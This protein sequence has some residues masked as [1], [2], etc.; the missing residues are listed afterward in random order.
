MKEQG[1]VKWFRND[2]GYGFITPD[3]GGQDL[4]VHFS[5][6]AGKGY[7]SLEGVDRVEFTRLTTD[8]GQQATEVEALTP[9]A[10]DEEGSES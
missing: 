6:I 8:R 2:K 3:D 10:T 4:F 7:R 9:P 5:G 1:R